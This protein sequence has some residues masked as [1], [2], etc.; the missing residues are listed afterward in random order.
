M[1]ALLLCL[2]PQNLSLKIGVQESSLVHE[3]C[4]DLGARIEHARLFKTVIAL[5][6]PTT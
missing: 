2:P 5:V 4:Q 6:T 1:G 3:K